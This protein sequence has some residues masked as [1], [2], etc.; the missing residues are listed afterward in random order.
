VKLNTGHYSQCLELV[1]LGL[2]SQVNFQAGRIILRCGR[3]MGMFDVG[4][5]DH[6]QLWRTAIEGACG[7]GLV[8]VARQAAHELRERLAKHVKALGDE[9]LSIN[10]AY[11]MQFF[12]PCGFIENP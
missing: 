8:H 10:D 11:S 9:N 7:A 3:P 4:G 1:L 6:A 5:G 2:G 12:I